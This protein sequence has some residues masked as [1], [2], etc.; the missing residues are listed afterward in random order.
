MLLASATSRLKSARN[1]LNKIVFVMSYK[2]MLFFEY[3]DLRMIF[4]GFQC[5]QGKAEY[6]H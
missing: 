4:V 1:E 5:L 6:V 3:I 2:M